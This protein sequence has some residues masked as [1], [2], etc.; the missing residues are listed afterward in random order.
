MLMCCCCCLGEQRRGAEAEAA[1]TELKGVLASRL[2]NI[3]CVLREVKMVSSKGGK[4][5]G[6]MRKLVNE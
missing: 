3:T 5:S 4:E 2:S 1:T 6:R